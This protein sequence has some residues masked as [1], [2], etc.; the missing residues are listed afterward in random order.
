[1]TIYKVINEQNN[2]VTEY[3]LQHDLALK[4]AADMMAWFSGNSYHVEEQVYDDI[5]SQE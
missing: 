3:Y 1:M 2:R 4:S 5:A